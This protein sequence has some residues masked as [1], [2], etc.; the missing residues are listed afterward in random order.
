MKR[1]VALSLAIVMI[2]AF[3]VSVAAKRSPTGKQYYK[4][5]TAVENP[6]MGT[7]EASQNKIE[8]DSGDPVTLTATETTGFFTRW[9]ITG[10]YEIVS[11]SIDSPELV[12]IPKSDINA[13]A[14]FSKE[15][16]YLNIT[17]EVVGDGTAS[18]DKPRVLKGADE[19]VTL[20][21]VDGKDTF[22][23]WQLQCDYKIVSGNLKSRTLKIIPYT[24]VH[25]IAYFKNASKPGDQ[26]GS[27]TSPKTGDP[28]YAVVP[29]MAIALAAAFISMKK[30]KEEN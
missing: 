8:K 24:D 11:G 7:V 22:V 10:D 19:V 17:V 23:E 12:I 2:F 9:I 30:L 5:T 29:F 20:T 14:N 1:F 27:S 4:I 28:L 6:G 25:A 18:V 15:E 16:D 21:A 26:N 13:T 3:A